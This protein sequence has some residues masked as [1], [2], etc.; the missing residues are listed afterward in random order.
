MDN[1]ETQDVNLTN[2]DLELD[3]DLDDQ[4]TETGSPAQADPTDWKAEALKYKSIARRLKGKKTEVKEPVILN[5]EKS[6]T[7]SKT[8]GIE[9]EVLDLRLDG[10]TKDEVEFIMRN[11]GRKT[12]EDKNS[13]VTIALASKR[14]QEQAEKA[15]AQVEDNTHLSEVERKFTPE[16]LANMSAEE[17]EKIL[18]HS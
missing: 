10:Y 16:Q 12:L 18:P 4:E 1:D 9:D 6:E 14:E 17:L 2:D 8:Y 7:S 13:M 15:A 11:G 3:L 5:N